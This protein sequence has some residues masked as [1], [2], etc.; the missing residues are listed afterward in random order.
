TDVCV[1]DG[2]KADKLYELIYPAKNPIVMGLSYAVIRDIGSFL[3]HQ[4]RDDAGNLNPLALSA[5]DVGI[6]R[7]YA[8]GIS[9]SAMAL[10]DFLYLGFNEDEQHRRVFDGVTIY[11]AGANRLINN[12]QFSHPTIM[13]LQERD[14][15]LPFQGPYTFAVATDPITGARD[16]ILKRP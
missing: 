15:D 1:F 7:A 16:G 13:S 2:F 10:R 6:R 5:E 9:S 14:H 12:V 3:R 8:S 4:R 11:S